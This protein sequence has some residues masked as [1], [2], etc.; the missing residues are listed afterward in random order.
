AVDD[1]PLVVHDVVVFENVFPRK[2]V[3]G[4]DFFLRVF[5]G[6]VEPGVLEFLP[7][8]ETEALHHLCHALG[9]TELHHEVVLETDVEDRFTGVALARTTSAQL[10][11]DPAAAVPLRANDKKSSSFGDTFA[12]LDV[13]APAGHVGGDSDRSCLT[14]A[15]DDLGLLKVELGVEDRMGDSFPL[16][17]AGENLGRFDAGGPEEDGLT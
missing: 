17:H 9:G 7:L 8:F 1:A 12:Q 6:F 11:V 5:Y 15:G 14:G 4:F 2:I 3:A 13:G 10:P 16:E